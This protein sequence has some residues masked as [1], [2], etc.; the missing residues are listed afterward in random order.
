MAPDV[1]LGVREERSGHAPRVRV[2][3]ARAVQHVCWDVAV[4]WPEPDLNEIWSTLH[5]I[6]GKHPSR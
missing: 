2:D 4:T 5:R 6:P 1:A 3:R